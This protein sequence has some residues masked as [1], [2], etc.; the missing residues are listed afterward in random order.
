MHPCVLLVVAIV[1]PAYLS[2]IP[3]VLFPVFTQPPQSLSHVAVSS[4]SRASLAVF[5]TSRCL[6][7]CSPG[8][9]SLVSAVPNECL[10][11][12]SL[13]AQVLSLIAAPATW[14]SQLVTR[15]Y[16]PVNTSWSCSSVAV[17]WRP[18]CSQDCILHVHVF[19]A[20][21]DV[22]PRCFDS[23]PQSC[24]CLMTSLFATSELRTPWKLMKSFCD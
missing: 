24:T 14:R 2:T 15:R 7:V 3:V 5:R 20:L 11:G 9:A 23:V 4:L 6:F 13:L 19:E 21:V 12:T 1:H 22:S 8:I 10:L 16:N 17:T 18:A